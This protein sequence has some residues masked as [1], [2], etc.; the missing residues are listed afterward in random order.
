MRGDTIFKGF[1]SSRVNLTLFPILCTGCPEKAD[2]I[3]FIDMSFRHSFY[4]VIQPLHQLC[5]SCFKCFIHAST[6][7]NFRMFLYAFLEI[8]KNLFDFWEGKVT[9]NFLSLFQNKNAP[10]HELQT[11]V[12]FD[13]L[14]QAA[15]MI[16]VKRQ[17]FLVFQCHSIEIF[18]NLLQHF[19]ILFTSNARG[20]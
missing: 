15:F 7:F 2:A 18:W 9:I 12:L 13:L 10:C 20:K 19:K 4:P 11:N 16:V 6:S 14:P 17:V 3:E 1:D 5:L 8:H